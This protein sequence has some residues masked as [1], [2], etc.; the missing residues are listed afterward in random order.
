VNTSGSDKSSPPGT[1]RQE[2]RSPSRT[3]EKGLQVLS[4]FDVTHPEWTLREIRERAGLPKA[5]GFRLVKTLENLK[6]LAYD[7]KSGAYHLGSAM[8][9]AA[10]LT[11]S[12]S[13]LVRVAEPYVQAL[14][15]ATTETV[16]LSVWTDQ[17]AM[18]VHTVYTPRPF[19]PHNPPGMV[20]SG[21]TNVHSKIFVAFGPESGWARAIADNIASRTKYSITDPD[22]LVEELAKVR[23]EGVA[24]GLEE[25]NLGMCAVGAPVFDSTGEVRAGLAL[26][27]PTERFGE[28]ERL[29]RAEAV[30]EVAASLSREL[31]YKGR[32]SRPS[33]SAAQC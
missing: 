2:P 30:A 10:Y 6:Y 31:G 18:I 3:L 20:M 25:H 7:P 23:R 32:D 9:K 19:R 5:T 28:A 26:V 33:P 16:D 13:G 8:L 24:F 4:L 12:H 1:A 11:L 22:R 14:A 17:G 27:A 21:L 15:E 29:R